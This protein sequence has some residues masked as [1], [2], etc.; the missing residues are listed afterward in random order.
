MSHL[1]I[2]LLGQVPTAVCDE[3]VAG[4]M[5]LPVRDAAMGTQGENIA[6]A[7]RNTDVRF[8]P[9]GHWFGGIMY[10]HALKAN[11]DNKWDFLIDSH[12]NVQVASYGPDQHYDWHIDTFPLTGNP[13]DRKITTVC[14]LNDTT[15][16]DGGE[17]QIRMYE[18]YV[19]PLSKGTI[20]AF[21]SFLEHRVTPVTAGV[22]V[23]ATIWLNGPRFR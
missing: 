1:P 13:L 16:F 12:E 23:S 18:E 21:P 8:A 17:F 3:A 4:F 5:Q 19:A 22:R 10:E 20:I 6:H 2:W 7:Q 11:Q 14:L 15:E 9:A